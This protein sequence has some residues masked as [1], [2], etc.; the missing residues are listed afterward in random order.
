M[1]RSQLRAVTRAP[2]FRVALALLA[3]GALWAAV[4][5]VDNET[6]FEL[7]G[8]ALNTATPTGTDWQTLNPPNYGA[9]GSLARFFKA[10]GLGG[11][12]FTTGGSKDYNDI[13]DWKFT[14]GT[15]PDKDE[16]MNAYA[17][18]Y[19]LGG[20]LGIY[21]GADR[22]S[23]DGNANI[24]FWFL[25]ADVAC[26]TG[27]ECTG[28]GGFTGNH[29]AGDILVVSEFV[30]GGDTPVIKVFKWVGSGGSEHQGT[31][32]LIYSSDTAKCQPGSGTNT[33]CG[34]VNAESTQATWPYAPKPN[35]GPAGYFPTAT[36]F[37]G[38]INLNALLGDNLPC[39][40]S[41]IAATRSSAT[42]SAV[43]KDFVVGSF[44]TCGVTIAKTCGSCTITDA[45][46]K[47]SYGYSGRVTNT[48]FSKLYN[49]DVIDDNGTPANTADDTTFHLNE[50]GAGAY[51]D[52]GPA[53]FKLT[54]TPAINR[55]SVKAASSP[56][57]PQT[58]TANAEPATCPTCTVNAALVPSKTCESKLEV[59]SGYV[60]VRVDYAGTVTNNG[61]VALTN[62]TL[63]D[64]SGTPGVTSDDKTIILP[65][66]L[67]P[68]EV[69][70][71]SSF[72]YPASGT[73]VTPGRL[74]FTDTVKVTA[75]PVI[76]ATGT[77]NGGPIS[78]NCLICPP[79][80]C[81][82]APVQ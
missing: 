15:S 59:K 20:Q 69:K 6:V 25:Q 29:V 81:P 10:D 7:D 23:N 32:D 56:S 82:L 33:V 64:D 4:N 60:V 52:F 38:G 79:G 51:W 72:Y 36:F 44:D 66:T 48:G 45:G 26:G 63:T 31:T 43:L 28:N 54:V 3:I 8:N 14:S 80:A 30:G 19:N 49:V 41:F 74:Q 78:A 76:G 47:F 1:S 67:A 75:T 65:G 21:F 61:D 9:N 42:I 16:I 34:I 46:T 24:G 70:N 71:F 77:V 55:A 12:I 37:E 17:A 40:S 73:E 50:L 5:Y 39:F 35:I 58:I 68:G 13:S 27:A 18:A 62:V 57:G 11:S 22:Y 2:L 53:T